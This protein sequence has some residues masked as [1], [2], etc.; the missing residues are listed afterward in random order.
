MDATLNTEMWKQL[1]AESCMTLVQKRAVNLNTN[2]F[3][4]DGLYQKPVVF[5]N[6]RYSD[7][8]SVDM[9]NTLEEVF[10]M[11]VTL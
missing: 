10:P 5:I 1:D 8:E 9:E 11:F 4:L 2:N 7:V 3:K 6:M